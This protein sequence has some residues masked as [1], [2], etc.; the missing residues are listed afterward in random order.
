MLRRLLLHQPLDVS[1]IG[2]E[3]PL[4]S[5][6]REPIEWRGDFSFPSASPPAQSPIYKANPN[7]VAKFVL[8]EAHGV[9]EQTWTIV[10]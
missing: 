4:F 5:T 6:S 10:V 8:G 9:I 3:V 7:L 2:K 1:T